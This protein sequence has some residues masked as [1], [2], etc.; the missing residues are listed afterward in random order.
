MDFSGK[1][2][3][4]TGGSRGIGRACA[5][6]FGEAKAT[7]VLTYV[8]NAAAAQET[9]SSVEGKG[10]MAEAVRLDTAD[11]AACSECIEQLVKKHGRLDVL[12]NNAGI[13]IDGLALR[14]KD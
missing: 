10:G 14:V 3:L 11:T 8:G 12:V 6:V 7:V 4:V 13:A 1:V 5:E 9:V 2:V